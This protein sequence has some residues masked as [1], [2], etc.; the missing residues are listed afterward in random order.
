GPVSASAIERITRSAITRL[1]PSPGPGGTEIQYAVARAGR[2]R[3]SIVDIAGRVVTTLVDG[4][5]R[6]GRYSA[7]WNGAT[8]G[9]RVQ[10]GMYFLRLATPDRTVVKTL[11]I[12]R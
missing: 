9:G 7:A 11:A 2:V 12:V 8:P 4:A 6:P 1:A 5:L 3:L 10:A